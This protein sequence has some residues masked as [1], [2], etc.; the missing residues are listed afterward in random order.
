MSPYTL[1]IVD[2]SGIQDYIFGANQLRQNIGASYLVDKATRGWA[3]E[4]LEELGLRHNIKNL[5]DTQE[6]FYGE[7]VIESGDVDAEVVYAG[8]GNL[9]I[10][11]VD[12]GKAESFTQ[13]LTRKVL[14]DAPGLR[15]VIAHQPIEWDTQPLGGPRGCLQAAME[16]LA[17]RKADFRPSVPLP[18]LGVTQECV[19]T[20]APAVTT[21]E[22]QPVSA[23]VL[24]KTKSEVVDAANERLKQFIDFR[25]FEPYSTDFEELGGAKGEKSYIAVV[26]TD[27]NGMGRR[28]EKLRDDHPA[29]GQN[30]EYVTKLR[31][32]SLSVQRAALK[33]L[34][35]TVDH[36][37]DKTKK[38]E[39]GEWEIA[40]QIN[41]T[42]N[43]F[44]F[45][46]IVFGGDD[47]T[48]ICDGRLGL[49]LAAMYLEKLSQETLDDG[50]FIACRAGVAGVKTHFPFARAYQLAEDLAASAKRYIHS[51][52]SAKDAITALDW[53]F[54]TSGVLF[55]LRSLR[56]GEYRVPA[57]HL[58]MRPVRISPNGADWRS[59]ENFQN[60]TLAFGYSQ[61]WAGRRNKVKALRGALRDGPD[62]VKNFFRVNGNLYLP[63]MDGSKTLVESGWQDGHCGYFDAVEAM[64]FFTPLA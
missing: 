56:A 50:D 48:F 13:R 38:N 37:I 59:W 19:F 21:W 7:R 39:K 8:G 57:G 2:T 20:G 24:A 44:P 49:N 36:L 28:I 27:G 53:H 43:Q 22:S 12:L 64:D 5:D 26:H 41:L 60:A 11:F 15:V 16:D 1:T 61:Q 10:L 63:A 58:E 4:I 51:L 17:R 47:L 18:G 54:A 23:E 25:G 14:K 46:P 33:A 40:G 9:V 52:D 42:G 6:P 32:F 62:A 31:A 45:R 29:A 3:R 55:D 34:Q 30:R 35:A